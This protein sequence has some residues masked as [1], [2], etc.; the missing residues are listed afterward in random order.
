MKKDSKAEIP[1]N[2]SDSEV[3]LERP[4][5][6]CPA[7]VEALYAQADAGRWGL[8]RERF[9]AALERSAKKRLA[10][11]FLTREKL[12]EFLRGLHLEDLALASACAEGNN[13][14]WEH[15]VST[16]RGYLRASASAILRCSSGAPEACELADSLFAELYGLTDGQRGERSLFRYFHGRSSL[17]TWLRAVMAQRHIDGIRAGRR[18]EELGDDD[19][20]DANQRVPAGPL[21]QPADP[22]RERYIQAFREA[23]DAV[24]RALP[25][26][27]RERLRLYYAQGSTL[28]EIGRALG[29]HESS[30]S[31]NLDRIRRELRSAV[32]NR[33]KQG[34]AAS[35][36][37]AAEPALSDAEV[38]LC[39]EY[40][41][42][43]A[44]IDL[45]KLFPKPSAQTPAAGRRDS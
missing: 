11:G 14:A 34:R 10:S 2:K 36:G 35:N 26:H 13:S 37:S 22:H 30:V 6:T 12:E 4:L 18:F 23:L 31:R 44:P 40:V 25:Q 38:V 33:L 20:R 17:K 29:E 3:D 24:L 39:F 28:A 43:D 8:P 16:Y 9:A 19:T 27:D 42:A 15:F 32:E 41:A 1:A 45:D 21:T 5:A 7:T